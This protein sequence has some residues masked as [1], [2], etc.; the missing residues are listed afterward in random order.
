M[1]TAFFAGYEVAVKEVEDWFTE[2]FS[3]PKKK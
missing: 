2:N 3:L 1:R